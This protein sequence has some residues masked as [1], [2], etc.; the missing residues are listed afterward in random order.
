MIVLLLSLPLSTGLVKIQTECK[1]QEFQL[2]K[3]QSESSLVY[4][5]LD[6][7]RKVLN[8]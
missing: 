4:P 6:N 5:K 3:E 8:W 1:R 7:F 2:T